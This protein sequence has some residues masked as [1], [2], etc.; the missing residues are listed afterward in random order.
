MHMGSLHNPPSSYR[1]TLCA[2]GGRFGGW[3]RKLG[4]GNNTITGLI[5]M[6]MASL[7]FSREV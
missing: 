7:T 2:A 1:Y 5:V 4:Q 6:M 3:E